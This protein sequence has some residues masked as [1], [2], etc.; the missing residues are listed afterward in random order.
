M[1]QNSVIA[2]TL[3]RETWVINKRNGNCSF[4]EHKFDLVGISETF[5]EAFA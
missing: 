1:R 2:S 5:W 4:T 3:M